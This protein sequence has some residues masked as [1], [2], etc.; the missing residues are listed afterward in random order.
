MKYLYRALPAIGIFCL[1]L[2][3]RVVYNLTVGK[4]YR[5]AYDASYYYK[6]ALAIGNRGCYCTGQHEETTR[7]PLWPFLMSIVFSLFDTTHSIYARL[8]LSVLD[9]GT[10]LFVFFL[11]R[12]I[13]GKRVAWITGVLAAIYPGLFI[14]DGWLYAEAVYTFFLAAFAYSLY[15]FQRNLQEPSTIPLSRKHKLGRIL[16]P[17]AAGLSLTLAAY[18]RP[19]GPLLLGMVVLWAIIVVWAKLVPWRA[20]VQGVLIIGALTTLL[21]APWTIRNYITTHTFIPVATGSGIVLSGAYNDSALTGDQ[22]GMWTPPGL[23]QPPVPLHGHQCCDYTGESDNT[24]YAI[25]W[26]K[27]H[28]SS[29]PY[30]LGLHFVNMWKPYTSEAGL[31]F[32]EFPHQFS[33][34]VVWN[35]IWIMTPL[36]Y[37]LAAASLLLTWKRWR[38]ELCVLYVIIGGIVLQN[39]AFYGSSRFRAPIEPLLVVLAGGTIW[40]LT[41]RHEGMRDLLRRRDGSHAL[42]PENPDSQT[43]E[44]GEVAISPR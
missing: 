16:W 29:M 34:Q 13:F 41:T 17:M 38:G 25:H 27:T 5:V 12:D 20:T 2:L 23:V 39:V 36:L 44:S 3:I 1:A 37:L 9:S 26:I 8:F 6:L 42:P 43:S 11:A 32:I 33:S 21:I 18:D 35:M 19:N 4:H 22:P 30:L 15:R 14:Y 7:A 31:P 10:C 28:L 40:W 24:H